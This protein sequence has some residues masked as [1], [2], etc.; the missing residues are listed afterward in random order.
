[1]TKEQAIIF[2]RKVCA[3][4][5]QAA[6]QFGALATAEALAIQCEL[7]FKTINEAPHDHELPDQP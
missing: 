4:R 6:G 2:L 1:M 3:E 7:A 5:I